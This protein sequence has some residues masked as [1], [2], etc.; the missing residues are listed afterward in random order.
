MTASIKIIPRHPP[1][2]DG[3]TP[4]QPLSLDELRAIGRR[5]NMQPVL[6]IN[7]LDPLDPYGDADPIDRDI[8]QERDA[9]LHTQVNSTLGDAS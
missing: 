8:E 9:Q 5:A 7:S 1:R 6:N 4:P 3:W 2:T